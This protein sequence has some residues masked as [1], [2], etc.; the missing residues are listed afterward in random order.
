MREIKKISCELTHDFLKKIKFSSKE[1]FI[2]IL[3]FYQTFFH[4]FF[5]PENFKPRKILR[6]KHLQ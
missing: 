5:T 6:E 1:H 2:K 4:E 3:K